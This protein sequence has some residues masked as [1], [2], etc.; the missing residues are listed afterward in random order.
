MRSQSES[1]IEVLGVHSRS[2]G[3]TRV[4]VGILL[5]VLALVLV[6]IF[7][8]FRFLVHLGQMNIGMTCAENLMG[9]GKSM[10]AYADAYDGKFPRAG[11]RT[12]GWGRVTWDA[13]SRRSA[14]GLDANDQGG[15]SSVSSSLY[16]LVRYGEE[17]PGSFVCPGDRGTQRWSGDEISRAAN[18]PDCWDFGPN[19]KEHCS[20]AYH[21]PFGPMP[22]TTSMEPG[23]P[24][25]ADR[26]PWIPSP[27][28]KG[29][30]F[31]RS[32]NG[33]YTFRGQSGNPKDAIYGNTPV[34]QE[35]GQNV[36]FLDS[37]VNFEK[38]PYCGLYDDNI[39]TVSTVPDKGDPL[40]IAP[41]PTVAGATPRN[42]RDSVL[43][44]D[45]PV[46]PAT[47]AK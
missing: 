7:W 32:A 31:P 8:L 17:L 9:I 16:L 38:R 4:D 15:Q 30:P 3:L 10:L 45:P 27:G 44:H 37:H 41:K 13:S 39:Y 14:Y 5:A 22:L 24:V 36:L 1:D 21:S 19:A 47:G 35:D 28:F 23:S 43:V 20:Y 11:G 33:K 26:N 34:H 6:S 2:A 29:K 42:R 12:S 18:F 46:R 25:I 40:G